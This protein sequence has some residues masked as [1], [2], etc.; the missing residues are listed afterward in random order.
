MM[1]RMSPGN[2]QELS[3]WA[4][5]LASSRGTPK[6]PSNLL[7]CL[8]FRRC[9]RSRELH[10]GPQVRSL[11][12]VLL[13]AIATLDLVVV[14]QLLR[15]QSTNGAILGTVKDPSGAAI[16]H[17]EVTVTD[18]QTN[19]SKTVATGSLGDYEAPDLLPGPYD[20]SVEAHG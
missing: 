8:T 7:A 19:L 17:A 5:N 3:A 1:R 6:N 9:A 10:A 14:P 11:S 16:P 20:V 4:P 2:G 13:M 15:A 12:L 18:E